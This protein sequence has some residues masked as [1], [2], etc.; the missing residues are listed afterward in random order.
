MSA[1]CTNNYEDFDEDGY[2]VGAQP[3]V[4]KVWAQYG[5]HMYC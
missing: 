2:M 5:A 3:L 4:G 1:T